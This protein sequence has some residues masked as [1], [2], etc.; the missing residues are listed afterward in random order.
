MIG[1]EELL[2]NMAIMLSEIRDGIS[3]INSMSKE[4]KALFMLSIFEE[5]P[6]N[7][8]NK[9]SN[10]DNNNGGGYGHKSDREKQNQQNIIPAWI[11]LLLC[12]FYNLI[13][14]EERESG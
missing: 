2:R 11:A 4:E 5:L 12:P 3:A 10:S 8:K 1:D 9:Q 6:K 13:P 14:P 7:V